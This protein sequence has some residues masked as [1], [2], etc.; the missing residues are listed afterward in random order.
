M[1]YLA[2]FPE[3]EF[4]KPFCDVFSIRDLFSNFYGVPETV[5]TI[6]LYAAFPGHTF[7]RLGVAV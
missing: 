2:A 6:P 7:S 1:P 5:N 4:G 3:S